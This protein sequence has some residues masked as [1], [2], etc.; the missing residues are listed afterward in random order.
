MLENLNELIERQQRESESAAQRWLRYAGVFLVSLCL[1][2]AVR[3]NQ[4]PGVE[5]AHHGT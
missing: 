4:I 3:R 1:W 5:A 2:R